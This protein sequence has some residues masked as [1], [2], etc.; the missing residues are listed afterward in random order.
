M[1]D[2]KN[3]TIYFNELILSSGMYLLNI[4]CQFNEPNI[5]GIFINQN[6]DTIY[7][8]ETYIFNSKKLNYLLVHLILNLNTNDIISIKSLSNEPSLA[9]L[10]KLNLSSTMIN[11]PASFESKDSKTSMLLNNFGFTKIVNEPYQAKLDKLGSLAM[12]KN[13]PGEKVKTFSSAR[14]SEKSKDFL[15]NEP[16][17][18]KL[19]KLGS[20]AMP[21]NEP[22]SFES[23]KIKLLK[24]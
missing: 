20:L 7:H 1:F 2:I 10:E 18:A 12:P 5:I 21:K 23:N 17:Q 24:L 6:E 11:E 15:D 3:K 4:S 22:A 13:E 14:L 8:T 9:K 16:Y 19:D